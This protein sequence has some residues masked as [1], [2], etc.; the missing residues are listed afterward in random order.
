MGEYELDKWE[1]KTLYENWKKSRLNLSPD[2]QRSK[3]WNDVMKYDLIDTVLHDWPMGIILLN[4]QVDVDSDGEPIKK[5]DVADGQQRLST[6]FQYRDG[7]DNWS[8]PAKQPSKYPEFRPYGQ[9]SPARQDRFDSHKVAVALMKDYGVDEVLDIF[10][11]LQHSKP[12]VIGE[13]V[14]ALRSEFKKYIHELISHRVFHVSPSYRNRDAF[15]NFSALFFKAVY[16]ENP[17]DRQEYERLEEFLRH[18]KV[19][20]GKAARSMEETKRILNF[21]YRVLEETQEIAPN[22]KEIGNVR[23]L[24]WSFAALQDLLKNFALSGREHL[25]ARG[26]IEYYSAKDVEGSDEWIAYFKT[27]RTGRIDTQEVRD[28]LEQ[29][30]NRIILAADAEPLDSTRFFTSAQRMAIFDKS[31]GKCANCNIELSRTNFHADHIR[32]HSQGGATVVENGQALCTKCNRA[33][34]DGQ[35][36]QPI[37]D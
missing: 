25:V 8:R 37:Q 11:R 6:L 19:D 27:G 12:L 13:K 35:V 22:F 2:Y 9:L 14:K 1:I 15:W 24:K 34:K 28:C 23:L 17:Y 21:L 10:S 16:R 29:L 7:E 33:K 20:V 5:Y 36:L 26:L 3:V 4:V 32:P 30:S 31:D 18:E